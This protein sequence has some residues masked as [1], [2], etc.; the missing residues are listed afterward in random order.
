MRNNPRDWTISDLK[1]LAQ[2]YG[3]D[4]RQPGTSHVTFSHVK[5]QPLTVP[6]HKPIKAVYVIRFIV[7]IDS[8]KEDEFGEKHGG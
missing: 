4:W 7:L 3:M 5:R 1:V 6:A 2:R 8:L